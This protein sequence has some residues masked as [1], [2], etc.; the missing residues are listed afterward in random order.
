LEKEERR[1]TYA[2]AS[3]AGLIHVKVRSSSLQAFF[4][5]VSFHV[6]MPENLFQNWLLSL[7]L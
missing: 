5:E 6:M 7:W 4:E 1:K 3:E 2:H